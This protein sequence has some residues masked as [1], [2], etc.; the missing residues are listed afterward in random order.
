MW[1]TLYV[2]T[3]D[4][5]KHLTECCSPLRMDSRDVCIGVQ[6]ERLGGVC[7]R[8]LWYTLYV[9]TRDKAKHLTE[10]CSLLR[11]DSRDVCVGVESERFGGVCVWQ[12]VDVLDV[13]A[14][15]V[16]LRDDVALVEDEVVREHVLTEPHLTERVEQ[17]L[18]VV[19]R[20]PPPVLDLP[21]HVADTR[22][23]HTLKYAI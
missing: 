21:Q 2:W 18:V 8:N 12:V 10:C 23:V 1:Y 22:P 4:K 7:D 19:V 3:R 16:A 6:S 9:W 20:H 14:D 11:I 17:D 5:A 15:L 13:L